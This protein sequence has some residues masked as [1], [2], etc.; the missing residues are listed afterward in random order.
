MPQTTCEK[1][2]KPAPAN[3]LAAYSGRCENCFAMSSPYG[4]GGQSFL[5]RTTELFPRGREP[6]HKSYAD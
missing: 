4:S 5:V 6:K 3:E 2:K 1:C